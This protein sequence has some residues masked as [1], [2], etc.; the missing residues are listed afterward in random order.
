MHTLSVIKI[1]KLLINIFF[2]LSRVL[3]AIESPPSF[4]LYIIT[5]TLL[6]VHNISFLYTPSLRDRN[7]CK[8]QV[9]LKKKAAHMNRFSNIFYFIK[10]AL[11]LQSLPVQQSL[12][13]RLLQAL[14]AS[15][16]SCQY[17]PPSVHA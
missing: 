1:A 14:Q 8:I 10:Q 17:L 5:D 16:C 13:C 15:F 9:T 2:V 6:F 4:S 7:L 11:P 3:S 12:P